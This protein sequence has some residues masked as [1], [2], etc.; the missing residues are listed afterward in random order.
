MMESLSDNVETN[1]RIANRFEPMSTG[2]LKRTG[3]FHTPAVV[4][5]SERLSTRVCQDCCHWVTSK[6]M[7]GDPIESEQYTPWNGT[8]PA[9]AH[10]FFLSCALGRIAFTS[11]AHLRVKNVN[12]VT[13]I[14]I[15]H[16]HDVIRGLHQ[17]H[18]HGNQVAVNSG[19][20]PTAHTS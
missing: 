17:A 14:R 6:T 15:N 19:T 2:E 1:H 13:V 7:L 16:L 8:F 12:V 11:T 3:T 20:N 5:E 18:L 9:H 10:Y 4:S